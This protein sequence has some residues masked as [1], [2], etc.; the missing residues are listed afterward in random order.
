MDYNDEPVLYCSN[1]LSLMVKTTTLPNTTIQQDYC[2]VCGDPH[3]EETDIET[4]EA[5]YVS[6]YGRHYIKRSRKLGG[7][8]PGENHTH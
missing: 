3:I 1:C 8:G 5:L 6:L 7:K 2:G 4:W